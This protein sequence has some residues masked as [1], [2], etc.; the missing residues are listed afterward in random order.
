MKVLQISI[1][2]GQDCGIALFSSNLQKQLRC[3]GIDVK[4]V[5]TFSPKDKPDIILLQHHE[6]L[7][8]E[9]DVIALINASSAPV[10][11]FAHSNGIN[12][13]QNHVDG[14]VAMCPN[15][16][17]S[18]DT[19]T[20][21]FPH[22]AWVPSH[23]ENRSDL[24]REFNLPHNRIIIGTNGF[25]K[26]ERQFEEII[27]ALLPEASINDW[28]IELITSP[29]RLNSPGLITKLTKMQMENPLNFRFEHNFLDT[30][31]LNRRLQACDLLWC[32]TQAPSSPYASGV[33]SDQYASGT[34]II[35]ADKLQ[36]RHILGLPNTDVGPDSISP[37]IEHLL[38]GL[39]KKEHQR[40]D[41]ILVSWGNFM[42]GLATFLEKISS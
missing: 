36:H 18:T 38:L 12:I 13:L 1:T 28:F 30:E 27:E 42:S 9:A 11:L 16:I 33:I 3:I 23:L 8:T 14:I 37:F 24:R 4:T 21:F 22:P 29:W 5:N 35:A 20:Y 2:S 40:H 31:T 26:F 7:I 17:K 10:I 25:L 32:W 6:E 15:I 39:H 19:P 34:R 41:P